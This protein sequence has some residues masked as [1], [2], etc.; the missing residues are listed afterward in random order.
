MHVIRFRVLETCN[1][2]LSGEAWE[3]VLVTG[4]RREDG[5]RAA[6]SHSGWVR[7]VTDV[8]TAHADHSPRQVKHRTHPVQTHLSPPFVCLW[9]RG[10]F[11]AVKEILPLNKWCSCRGLLNPPQSDR[12][13]R[14]AKDFDTDSQWAR[15]IIIIISKLTDTVGAY[16]PSVIGP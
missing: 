9:P 15:I 4:L 5:L 3:P 6:P 10:F 16:A 11:F 14:Y 12:T 7:L 13:A 1:S 8:C 2:Y